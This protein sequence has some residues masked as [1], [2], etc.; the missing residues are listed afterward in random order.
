MSEKVTIKIKKQAPS[1]GIEIPDIPEKLLPVM[2]EAPLAPGKTEFKLHDVARLTG[3]HRVTIIRME[4][5]GR[6]P[7]A[8]WRRKPQP[9]R[10]YS[11]AEVD[12]IIDAICPEE[13]GTGRHYI[14]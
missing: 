11:Q 2:D 10:V 1:P 8:R 9:H 6:I 12:A 4:Q 13:D 5:Q 7:V 3:V 14:D